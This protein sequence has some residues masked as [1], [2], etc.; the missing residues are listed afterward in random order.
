MSGGS[1]ETV[2]VYGLDPNSQ[3]RYEYW[4]KGEPGDDEVT[5]IILDMTNMKAL[6]KK[7]PLSVAKEID[8]TAGGSKEGINAARDELMEQLTLGGGTP[9]NE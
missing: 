1:Y 6:A 2:H 8:N 5:F 9:W 4:C 3:H 7:I